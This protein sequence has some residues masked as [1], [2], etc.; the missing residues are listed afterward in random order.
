LKERPKSGLLNIDGAMLMVNFLQIFE[1]PRPDLG[2]GA[3]L[4]A[5]T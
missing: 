4:C 1:F 3:I 2:R 5:A